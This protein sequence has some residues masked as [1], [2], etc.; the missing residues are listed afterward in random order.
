MDER[1]DS[2]QPDRR[3][4]DCGRLNRGRRKTDK[5]ACPR[6]G[7]LQSSV[8]PRRMTVEEQRTEGFWRQRECA[9]CGDIFRTVE[10]VYRPP[11]DSSSTS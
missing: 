10:V 11:L 2:E 6:C 7:C 5:V 9:H 4:L 3:K 8:V 1:R